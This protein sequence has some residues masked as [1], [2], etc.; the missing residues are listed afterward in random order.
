MGLGSSSFLFVG[1]LES[2]TNNQPHKKR[3]HHREIQL[4]LIPKRGPI[5]TLRDIQLQPRLLKGGRLSIAYSIRTQRHSR[6]I[7]YPGYKFLGTALCAGQ[8][9]EAG[10]IPELAPQE[11]YPT[12]LITRGHH[13]FEMT[14]LSFASSW[15]S[16][17]PRLSSS[18]CNGKLVST[19]LV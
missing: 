16:T 1:V 14:S 13:F 2:G 8:V 7:I 15:L 5:R 9:V 4:P 6:F 18:C 10:S 12:L 17:L 3:G 19:N 11:S